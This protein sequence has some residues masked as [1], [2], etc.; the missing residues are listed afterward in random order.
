[1]TDPDTEVIVR[2]VKDAQKATIT[3]QDEGG[4]QLGAIDEVTGKSGEP[5]SYTTTA[6]ITELTNQGY[7]VVTDGFTKEGGQVFDTDKATDQPFEVVVRAKVVTVTPEDPKNPGTPVDP[8]NPDGPKWPDGVKES[9]LNQTVTRVIKYQYEDGSQAQPDVV[10]TLTYK[11]TAT[12]NLV[13]KEVTYGEWTSTDNA[14]D[15]VDTPTIA[16]YTPDKASVAAEANVPAE[17]ADKEVIVKYVKD[18]QKATITY[19]DDK[20]T[21]L[22]SVDEVTGKSGEPITY[23]TTARIT[24]LKNKG[25][26]VV[27]DGFTKDGGQ[28]F[29]TDKT[30]D[31]PFEVVVRAKVVT[32]TPEDPKNPGTE[33]DPG[34]P[35]GPKWPDGVKE[36]D[37]N[38]TVTRVIKYQYEDGS[39]AKPDMVE[40]L[41]YKRTATV[42]LVTKEVTYG[43]WTSTDNDFDKVDTPAI[44]GYTPDKA[45][46]AAE[47]DVPAEA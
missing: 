37:L 19:K 21:T 29:D 26:E 8:G 38:Q 46:V 27:T 44:A 4:K 28:V 10:E 17:A 40:T 3:Y 5:I 39:Q 34:N 9:D 45:S 12:V 11:R 14:F 2:Y 43:E 1:A 33:V 35:D 13:T 6:R 30:T 16:G 31:Q 18:A 23:T 15:K 41:T 25:Y 20:G 42:N 36:S 7:E 32:V 47:A 22:G 24:E